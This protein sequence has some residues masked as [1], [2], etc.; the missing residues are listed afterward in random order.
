MKGGYQTI[1]LSSVTVGTQKTIAGIYNRA[2]GNNGKPFMIKTPDGQSVFAEVKA[3]TN[4][5]LTAYLG[6]DGSTYTV[7]ISNANKV[8]ITKNES[9]AETDA[10]LD[11]VEAIVSANDIL[12]PTT[13]KTYDGSTEELTFTAPKDGYI[14]IGYTAGTGTATLSMKDKD[15]QWREPLTVTSAGTTSLF[16]KKGMVFKLTYADTITAGIGYFYGIE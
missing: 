14:R 12:A 13:I 11:A 7:E 10:R 1:D 2:K 5:Y 15:G 9:G 4:K 16:V 6:A 3:G 8:D